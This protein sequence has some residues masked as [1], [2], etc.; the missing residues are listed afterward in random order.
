MP[1]PVACTAPVPLPMSTPASVSVVAPVPPLATGSVPVTHEASGRPVTFVITH[2]AGVPSAGAMRACPL[3]RTTVPVNVG[4]AKLAFSQSLPFN[5]FT[6]CRMV[7]VAATV[8]AP[9]TYPVRTL[10]ITVA[11]GTVAALPTDVTSPVRLAFV[12][13]FHAVNPDAVPVTFVITPLAGV[14]RAGVVRM[15]E[16]SVLFV[17]VAVADRSVALDVLST[18]HSPTAALSRV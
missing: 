12:V 18:F 6:A 16:V 7:S 5:L 9:E 13:T 2:E 3:G 4:E 11:L 17:S 14:P 1:A 15:G 8:P 10:P